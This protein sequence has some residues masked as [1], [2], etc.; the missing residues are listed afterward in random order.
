MIKTPTGL[1]IDKLLGRYECT[2]GNSNKFY[3]VMFHQDDEKNQPLFLVQWGKI[4]KNP[5]GSKVLDYYDAFE[6]LRQRKRKGYVFIPGSFKSYVEQ[7]KDV[8]QKTALSALSQIDK[9]DVKDT[10]VSEIK[11]RPIM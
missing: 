3:E 10:K 9:D 1:E 7:R 6:K 11:K 4:G 5:Q 8:L 2:E